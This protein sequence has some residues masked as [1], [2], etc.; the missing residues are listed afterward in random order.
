MVSNKRRQSESGGSLPPGV[1]ISM[2]CKRPDGLSSNTQESWVCPSAHAY[3]T[4][5]WVSEDTLLTVHQAGAFFVFDS[6]IRMGPSCVLLSHTQHF[7]GRNALSERSGVPHQIQPCVGGTDVLSPP[8]STLDLGC[9]TPIHFRPLNL[10]QMF[11]ALLLIRKCSLFCF[12]VWDVSCSPSLPSF[13]CFFFC[14]S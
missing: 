7:N 11:L 4:Q 14:L 9:H 2:A 10:K 1:G 5:E 12:G 13:A 3:W 6:I 8:S